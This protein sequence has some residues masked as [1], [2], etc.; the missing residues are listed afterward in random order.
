MENKT[1]S[2]NKNNFECFICLDVPKSPVAI[3]CGHIFCWRC[4]QGWVS[5]KSDLICPVCRNGID[6]SR[7]IPLYT[8]NNEN[9]REDDRPKVERVAPTTINRGY[10]SKKYF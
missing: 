1:N 4:L 6:M 8:G 7:V 9:S 10:V 3:T 5:G 2:E